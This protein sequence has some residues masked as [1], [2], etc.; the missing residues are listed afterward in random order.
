MSLDT[1]LYRGELHRPVESC[2]KNRVV[3]DER[4]KEVFRIPA[5]QHRSELLLADE[6]GNRLRRSKT[7]HDEGGER[8]HVEH[9]KRALMGEEARVLVDEERRN[10]LGLAYKRLQ[11]GIEPVDVFLVKNYIAH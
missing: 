6:A 5:V 8:R 4:Y 3:V 7:A 10:D 11:D 1:G 9:R 2:R